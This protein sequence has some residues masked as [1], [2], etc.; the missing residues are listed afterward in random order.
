MCVRKPPRRRCL[1]D[2]TFLNRTRLLRPWRVTPRRK[3]YKEYKFIKTVVFKKKIFF[4]HLSLSKSTRNY[5]ILLSYCFASMFVYC[6]N[7]GIILFCAQWREHLCECNIIIYASCFFIYRFYYRLTSVVVLRGEFC[8]II[9][10]IGVTATIPVVRVPTTAQIY[11]A[12]VSRVTID[13]TI[14]WIL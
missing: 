11:S 7:G 5:I 13:M 10:I 8:S 9:I 4:Y 12:K 14:D 2:D 3:R 6:V 1:W